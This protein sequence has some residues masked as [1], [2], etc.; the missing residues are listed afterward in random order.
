[1]SLVLVEE[2]HV[3][4]AENKTDRDYADKLYTAF[5]RAGVVSMP[6]VQDSSSSSSGSLSINFYLFQSSALAKTPNLHCE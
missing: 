3:N 4:K 2:K 5:A 1:M 6:R